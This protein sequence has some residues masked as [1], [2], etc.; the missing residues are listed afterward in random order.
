MNV[1]PTVRCGVCLAILVEHTNTPLEQRE[2][3][4]ECGSLGRRFDVPVSTTVESHAQVGIKARTPGDKRPFQE[5]KYGDDVHRKS[6]IWH[7]VERTI[8]RR[9][10]GTASRSRIRRLARSSATWTSR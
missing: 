10:I 5:G 1:E 9:R 6:G 4:H 7:V 3:C 8:D 2:P